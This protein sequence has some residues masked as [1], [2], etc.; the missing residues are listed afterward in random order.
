MNQEDS[1]FNEV[2]DDNAEECIF[3]DSSNILNVKSAKCAICEDCGLW[4][5]EEVTL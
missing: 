5:I 2:S 3:C 4:Q 1:I